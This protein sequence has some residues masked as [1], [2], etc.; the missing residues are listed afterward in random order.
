MPGRHASPDPSRFRR[1][2][3]RVIVLALLVVVVGIAVVLVVRLLAGGGDEPESIPTAVESS[4]PSP[5]T[6]TATTATLSTATT[7][8]A[9][10]STIP[11]TTL[12][13]VR[14]PDQV[15]V[16]VLNSTRVAGLAGR[17]TQQLSA[18][19]YHMLD[20]DNHPTALQTSVIWYVEGFEREAGVLAGVI[21]DATVAAFPGDN[22]EAALTVVLGVSYRE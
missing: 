17:V 12:P 13:P 18:L 3:T 11:T 21:A 14:D 2:L 6:S 4:V 1:D 19:G 10:T 22:P 15:V 16:V 7:T 20:P 9:P 5:P 8:S